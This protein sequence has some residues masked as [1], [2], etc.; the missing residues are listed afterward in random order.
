[1]LSELFLKPTI[2]FDTNLLTFLSIYP[3]MDS[4]EI[5]LELFELE[6]LSRRLTQVFTPTNK[7]RRRT[8]LNENKNKFLDR[9]EEKKCSEICFL[10]NSICLQSVFS[11]ISLYITPL[12]I[13]LGVINA[14]AILYN[15]SN[16][17]YPSYI[18]TLIV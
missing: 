2:S 5:Y 16:F 7:N 11:L 4:L 3:E 12:F 14:S 17:S 15:Q 18:V 13:M 6:I 8:E 1:M 9:G 10:Y